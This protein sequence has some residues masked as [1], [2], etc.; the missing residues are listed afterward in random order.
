VFFRRS[1]VVALCVSLAFLFA[2]RRQ[3]VRLVD[4]NLTH[5]VSPQPPRV[6]P[7]TIDFTLTDA[8]KLVSGA[9][10]KVEAN[11]SHAGMA[12]IFAEATEEGVGHYRAVIDLS[13]AGDWVVIAYASLPNGRKIEY[14]F[15]IN[16]VVSS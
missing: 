11:M 6:G 8:G 10:I 1:S 15:E 13:M 9:Q 5:E 12:P 4:L 7:T 16:G 2:C 3:E 14:R